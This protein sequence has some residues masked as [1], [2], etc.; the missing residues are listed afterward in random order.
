[1]SRATPARPACT[2]RHRARA[3]PRANP[4]PKYGRRSQRGSSIRTVRSLPPAADEAGENGCILMARARDDGW[5]GRCSGSGAG[6]D[7]DIKMNAQFFAFGWWVAPTA[8]A[9]SA[10]WGAGGAGEGVGWRRDGAVLQRPRGGWRGVER[11]GHARRRRR[12]A[13]RARGVAGVG[14]RL[15]G[16]PLDAER[17]LQRGRRWGRACAAGERGQGGRAGACA[18]VE[19]ACIC[20]RARDR[21]MAVARRARAP[22]ACALTRRRASPRAHAQM[23]SLRTAEARRSP[24]ARATR[25]GCTRNSCYQ[26][27][28]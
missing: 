9:W 21:P 10:W 7:T 8:R 23:G 20:V 24:I 11:G 12:R 14:R 17:A 3:P 6:C 1:M 16:L 15:C 26:Q 13:R 28:G 25:G 4:N 5:V 27:E 19:L 18:L 22:R 2:P